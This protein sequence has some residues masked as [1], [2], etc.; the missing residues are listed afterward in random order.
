MR[1]HVVVAS[2]LAPA[3]RLY[4]ASLVSVLGCAN[5]SSV[6]PPGPAPSVAPVA[7]APE[8]PPG[9]EDDRLEYE[10]A[11]DS[12]T[13]GVE[14]ERL[15]VLLREHWDWT[16]HEAPLHATELG[17]HWFDD[18]LPD[19]GLGALEARHEQRVA[20]VERAREIER[21]PS[22]SPADRVTLQLFVRALEGALATEVCQFELWSISARDNPVATWNFL[23]EIH[24]ITSGTDAQRLLARYRQIP[25]A[26]DQE[27]ERLRAGADQGLYTNAESTRRVLAMVDRQLEQ[28]VI[29]WP[30]SA[31]AKAKVPGW[32]TAETE[33]Y[34]ARITEVVDTEIRPALARY[35]AFVRSAIL[36]HARSSEQSGLA[37]LA[38]GPKCYDALVRDYTTLAMSPAE[39]HDVGLREIERIDGE[40]A[41]LGRKALG[42]KTLKA[43]LA[44]L[45]GDPKLYFQT[46]AEVEAA[47]Q[48]ALD[49]AQ[50]RVPDF[51]GRLPKTD[52]GVRRI[53]DYE[54]PYTTIAYY[55]PPHA[56]GSKPGEYYINVYEPTTRPRYEARVLAFH[57]SVPGHHFQIALA[58]EQTSLPAFRREEGYTVFVEGWALYTERLADEMGLYRDDLD[59]LGMLSFD[60]WRA[61]RLVVDTGIHHLGWS[62]ERGKAFL[63]EHSALALNNID[64]EVDRYIVW[65]GQALAYKVG[66]LEILAL[67]AEAESVLGDD[68]DLKAFHDVTLGA[69]AVS[70]PVLRERVLAWANSQLTANPRTTQ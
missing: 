49:A 66:Q 30:L 43:T 5:T 34:G 17:V 40:I 69:G 22:L 51:F 27:I 54:A 20:F 50:A 33:A 10:Q 42:T 21:Q 64:N 55:R 65:P 9:P 26:I 6:P 37:A 7:V 8:E 59:R 56:D 60:A 18:K 12:A 63:E 13:T 44:K 62:R 48:E 3:G 52:C 2:R 68:F 57:E 1:K 70:L 38:L 47:A 35:A 14:D 31:P 23:P 46:S 41:R 28:P 39:V 32:S 11:L 45:R 58:Q 53:P 25:T 19:F 67:R 4:L 16:L 61:G 15:Q 24:K 36:P 29:G